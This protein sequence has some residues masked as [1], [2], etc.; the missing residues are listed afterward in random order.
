MFRATVRATE[1]TNVE[2]AVAD[3]RADCE[4][5]GLS[6]VL[7]DLVTSQTRDLLEQFI[8]RGKQLA[9]IG[10]QMQVTRE[11]SGEG[12]SVKLTFQTGVQHRR[13]FLTRML[14]SLR[15]R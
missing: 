10:S 9:S 11:L 8:Q 6:A 15:R 3:L 13:S 2:T 14:D 12:Y 5:E 1:V 4:H 7:T